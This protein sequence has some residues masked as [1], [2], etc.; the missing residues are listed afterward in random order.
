MA[1][2]GSHSAGQYTLEGSGS[3]MSPP[4]SHIR[5]HSNRERES[6]RTR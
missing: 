1:C 6:G 4:R 5:H 2:R 3:G